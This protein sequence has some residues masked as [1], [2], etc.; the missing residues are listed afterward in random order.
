MVIEVVDVLVCMEVLGL[1][2]PVLSVDLLLPT[3][4]PFFVYVVV[5]VVVVVVVT[6]PDDFWTVVSCC[7]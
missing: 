4:W 2:P 6:P 7:L 3:T 5:V 1:R